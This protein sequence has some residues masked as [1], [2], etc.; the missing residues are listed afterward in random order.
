MIYISNR[1]IINS[2]ICYNSVQKMNVYSFKKWKVK[3]QYKELY[4]TLGEGILFL[5]CLAITIATIYIWLY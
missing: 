5:G 2:G 4:K 3:Q 1:K